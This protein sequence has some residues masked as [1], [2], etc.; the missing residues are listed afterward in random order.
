MDNIEATDVL[1]TLNDDAGPAHVAPAGDHNDITSIEP[2][3]IGDFSLFDIKFDGVVDPDGG[4]WIADSPSVVGNNV[5]DALR[6][7]SHFSNLEKL[8]GSF[9]GCDAVDSEATFDVVKKAEVFTRL[10]NGDYI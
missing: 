8:V 7:K 6:T 9:L 3:E 1:L 5:W 10:F 4:V 2:D